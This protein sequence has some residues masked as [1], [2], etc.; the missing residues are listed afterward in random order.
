MTD[1]DIVFKLS[2]IGTLLSGGK[3]NVAVH[4]RNY[5]W[6][7]EKVEDLYEDFDN[8]IRDAQSHFLGTIIL[9]KIE[10]GYE[11]VD[12]QQRL[13]TTTIMV[14][15]IRDI[16]FRLGDKLNADS[17]QID[18]LFRFDRKIEGMVPKIKL[19]T[20]ND[21]YFRNSILA[22]PE[23]PER[24]AEQI[25]RGHSNRKLDE[26]AKTIRAKIESAL[27]GTPEATRKDH[28][29]RWL[30]FIEN[31][32][33][34]GVLTVPNEED[35]YLIFETQNDR[36]INVSEAD[37]VKSF[38][39]RLSGEEKLADVIA[40]WGEMVTPIE[41]LGPKE[42]LID[43]LR[44]LASV[45]YGLTNRSKVFKQIK[46]NN[47]AQ[48][49]AVKFIHQMNEWAVDY[50]A[51]L[52]PSHPKWNSYPPSI[53]KSLRTLALFDVMQI[54]YLML[55]V[56][57]HF[58][59]REATKAFNLFV[60]WIVRFFIAGAEKIG[61]V[62]KVYADL[63]HSIHLEQIK[64]ADA[65]VEKMRDH[66]ANDDYFKEQF[67]ST[68]VSQ[69]KLA[70]YYLDALERKKTDGEDAGLVPDD[71]TSKVN[72][73]HIIPLNAAKNWSHIEAESAKSLYKKLGNMVLLNAKKNSKIGDVT[74]DE[75]K[76]AFADSPFVL[77]KSV[78]KYATW[79][80]DEISKRQSELA[81]LAVKTW[82]LTV[83]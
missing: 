11:V 36:G 82:P 78:A 26:A 30:N 31:D 65:L 9:R 83:K 24:M 46:I 51:M 61:R 75:K 21:E 60:N 74:F 19:N 52:S 38:L 67:S 69:A 62:D 80:A 47:S 48:I 17:V 12:G 58:N 33:R 64:T 27:S 76:K 25:S 40:Q 70:R 32:A 45:F 28:L 56:A 41:E 68:S 8:A 77:T 6:P 81:E 5:D 18:F 57:H 54:R 72:L 29:K 1:T 2:G 13:A 59:E 39:F 53:R 23:S 14:A 73:E 71:D 4:Q 7:T 50:V 63:A 43:Y 34:V 10:D 35:A 22:H 16:F 42:Y 20:K 66:V 49:S 3:L 15:T 37:L 79:G 44:I 55:A